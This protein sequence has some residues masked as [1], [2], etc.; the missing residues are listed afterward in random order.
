MITFLNKAVVC[1][2]PHITKF[3]RGG[4]ASAV[5]G[6]GKRLHSAFSVNSSGHPSDR[7][8]INGLVTVPATEGTLLSTAGFYHRAS[9][10]QHLV[11]VQITSGVH[12]T[13]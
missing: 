3:H 8:I 12:R 9:T 2:C 6:R 1:H 11:D 13:H 7:D 10:L 4:G 5:N